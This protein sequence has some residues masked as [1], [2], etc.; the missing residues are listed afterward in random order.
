MSRHPENSMISHIRRKLNVVKNQQAARL[1]LELAVLYRE[2]NNLNAAEECRKWA[3][4]HQDQA[5]E[6]AAV[7]A[8]EEEEKA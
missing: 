3:S 7:Y 4:W 2:T 8:M 6:L 5:E 1:W